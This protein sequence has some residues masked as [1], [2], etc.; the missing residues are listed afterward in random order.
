MSDKRTLSWVQ[1]LNKQEILA[2]L[3]EHDV[4]VEK[5]EKFDTLREKLR[6]LIKK[7]LQHSE[8]SGE[9]KRL[10]KVKQQRITKIPL[11]TSQRFNRSS[12]QKKTAIWLTE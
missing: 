9:T 12:K 6:K 5:S 8:K 10:E 3:R 11:P 2:E 4:Q 7:K 1:T